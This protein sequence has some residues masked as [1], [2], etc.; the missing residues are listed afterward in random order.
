M[1]RRERLT[2][3][4]AAVMVNFERE[5]AGE[6]GKDLES[7]CDDRVK[8]CGHGAQSVPCDLRGP[9]RQPVAGGMAPRTRRYRPAVTPSRRVKEVG[10]AP[11]VLVNAGDR[12]VLLAPAVEVLRTDSQEG[13]PGFRTGEIL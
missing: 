2:S 8:S 12:F 11:G 5:P 7:V 10:S 6:G 13:V 1:T 3:A 9:V 4:A